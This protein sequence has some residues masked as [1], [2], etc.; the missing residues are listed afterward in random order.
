MENNEKSSS[1]C[2]ETCGMQLRGSV[3]VEDTPQ[4]NENDIIRHNCYISSELHWKVMTGLLLGF[5]NMLLDY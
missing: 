1:W 3:C 5:I 2:G 4:K